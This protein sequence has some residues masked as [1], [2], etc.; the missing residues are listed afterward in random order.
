MP[1]IPISTPLSPGDVDD[2]RLSGVFV[3]TGARPRPWPSRTGTRSCNGCREVL[4]LDAG[5]G[6]RV[7]REPFNGTVRLDGY[8]VAVVS[9]A[10]SAAIA[11]SKPA[12]AR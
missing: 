4:R 12:T 5:T 6:G 8:G 11:A 1:T 2:G 3:N 10:P 7:V 9:T